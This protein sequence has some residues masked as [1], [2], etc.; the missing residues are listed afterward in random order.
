MNMYTY[1]VTE[2]CDECTIHVHVCLWSLLYTYICMY[3]HDG[4]SSVEA[5]ITHRKV[6]LPLECWK[7]V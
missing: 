1:V 6:A 4:R 7:F 2:I 3:I 5:A